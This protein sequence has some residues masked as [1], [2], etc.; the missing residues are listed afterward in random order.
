[1]KTSVKAL[2]LGA[3]PLAALSAP[4]EL[5]RAGNEPTTEECLAVARY[6]SEKLSG[7]IA[8]HRRCLIDNNATSAS[9]RDGDPCARTECRDIHLQMNWTG[10]ESAIIDKDCRSRIVASRKQELDKAIE[11]D[12]Q[13]AA[14][15]DLKR[16][17]VTANKL[18][19]SGEKAVKGVGM[20]DRPL[21]LVIGKVEGKL[22]QRQRELLFGRGQGND[23]PTEDLD[24]EIYNAFYGR[25]GQTIDQLR[26]R[27]PV[28]KAINR[29]LLARLKV[30][31]DQTAGEVTQLVRDIDSIG[32]TLPQVRDRSRLAPVFYRTPAANP[33]SRKPVMPSADECAIFADEER[34]MALLTAD[35]DRWTALNNSCTVKSPLP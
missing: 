31:I 24:W 14:N 8:K 27:S 21:N 5:L 1:M 9:F 22:S 29:E 11:A 3:W 16:Q 26:A 4:V 19:E 32:A 23:V 17:L 7:L 13:Q 18:V 6:N 35:P 30:M 2:M 20:L 15:E 33:S 28:I 10:S 12:K 25:A 34:S